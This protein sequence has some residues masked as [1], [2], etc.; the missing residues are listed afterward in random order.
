MIKYDRISHA[1]ESGWDPYGIDICSSIADNGSM[2]MM[3]WALKAGYKINPVGRTFIEEGKYKAWMEWGKDY[4]C[5]LDEYSPE[6]Y[7]EMRG[8]V[9]EDS[10]RETRKHIHTCRDIVKLRRII[11]EKARDEIDKEKERDDEYFLT[12]CGQELELAYEEECE[13]DI[14]L[15]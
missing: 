5:V 4:D 7:Y 10:W 8:P 9:L 6:L 2:E 14:L 12:G 3:K 1:F 11:M 13:W 15:G